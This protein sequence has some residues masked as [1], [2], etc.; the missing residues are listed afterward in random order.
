MSHTKRTRPATVATH[1][2]Y[3]KGVHVPKILRAKVLDL[4]EI[5][6]APGERGVCWL[7]T[8][9][10]WEPTVWDP[11]M[12]GSDAPPGG[13]WRIG[14]VGSFPATWQ[15]FVRSSG[16]PREDA[17]RAFAIAIRRGSPVASWRASWTPI[18]EA[19]WC[20]VEWWDDE[21]ETWQPHASWRSTKGSA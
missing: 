8:S 9:P 21:T 17:R 12:G 1:W 11:S 14:V 6:I 2:H 19:S 18:P 20:A 15:D 5:G 13:R 7:T 16:I 4:A 10:D 3:T